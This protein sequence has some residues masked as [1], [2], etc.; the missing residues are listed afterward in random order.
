M[1][2]HPLKCTDVVFNALVLQFVGMLECILWVSQTC[3]KWSV[4]FYMVYE[5]IGR[6]IKCISA[7]FAVLL[8]SAQ[9]H[10][11]ALGQQNTLSIR[12]FTVRWFL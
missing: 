2:D 9:V 7:V 12:G 10:F 1:F 5:V 6:P 11:I 8:P 3:C 4:L